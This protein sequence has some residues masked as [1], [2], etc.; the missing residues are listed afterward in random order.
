MTTILKSRDPGCDAPPAGAVVWRWNSWDPLEEVIVGNAFGGAV[1]DWEP[2]FEARIGTLHQFAHNPGLRT[3]QKVK[4]AQAELDGLAD[5][6]SNRG[7]VVRRPDVVKNPVTTVTPHWTAKYQNGW[8]CPRDMFMVMG[9]EVIETCPNFRC[10]FFECYAHRSV[11]T[12]YFRRDPGMLWSAG[13][14]P[15][16]KDEFYR[17]HYG[18]APCDPKTGEPG[19]FNEHDIL[20]AAALRGEHVGVPWGEATFDGADA[21]NMGRDL[22]VEHT[23]TANAMGREW[24]RRK[25]ASKGIRVHDFHFPE[26]VKA[27]HIDCWVLPCRGPDFERD[28]PG[29]IMLG[30]G[31]QRHEKLVRLL[32]DNNWDILRPPPS[33]G[34]PLPWPKL[35]KGASNEAY[36]LNSFVVGPHTIVMEENETAHHQLLESHGFEVLKL[37]F[38]NT[39]EFGGAFNCATLDIRRRGGLRSFFPT[40]DREEDGFCCLTDER[41]ESALTLAKR[42]KLG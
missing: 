36:A 25:A 7:V 6:L 41:D 16:C 37:P 5:A 40:L 28:L 42:Q 23:H 1:P 29:K 17:P 26:H 12:S 13:P 3:E 19:L 38:R 10:R 21:M 4:L 39:Y 18:R 9:N 31:P 34:A 22:F 14:P 33:T 8:M 20:A 27:S 35:A 32:E 24:I 30:P 11:L 15:Q 2:A